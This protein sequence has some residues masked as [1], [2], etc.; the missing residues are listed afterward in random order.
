MSATHGTYRLPDG[1]KVRTAALRRYL[2]V[3]HY[4]ECRPKVETS[5]D[6]AI[7]ASLTRDRLAREFPHTAWFVIDQNNAVTA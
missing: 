5:C 7:H 6:D 3:A 1:S 2:I 4:K